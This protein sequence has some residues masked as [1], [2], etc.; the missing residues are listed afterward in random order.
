MD[1]V[2]DKLVDYLDGVES[3]LERIKDSYDDGEYHNMVFLFHDIKVSADL[4]EDV[5][6]HMAYR[7]EEYDEDL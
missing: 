2:R 7:E 1:E 5:I 6:T 3:I 4:M